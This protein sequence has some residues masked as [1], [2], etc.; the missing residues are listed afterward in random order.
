[1]HGYHIES[2]ERGI[3]DAQLPHRV[4]REESVMHSYHIEC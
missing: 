2:V 1:M 3:S 4:L